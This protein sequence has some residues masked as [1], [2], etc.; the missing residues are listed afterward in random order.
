MRNGVMRDKTRIKKLNCG[1]TRSLERDEAGH[2][3]Y[4]PTCQRKN[5]KTKHKTTTYK[6]TQLKT[7]TR[8]I[9]TY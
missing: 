7:E 8:T 5:Y 6:V 4:R 2:A 9:K 3:T 1:L